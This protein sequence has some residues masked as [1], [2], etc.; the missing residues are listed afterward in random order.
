MKIMS[1]IGIM[2]LVFSSFGW[3]EPDFPEKSIYHLKQEWRDAGRKKVALDSLQGKIQVVTFIYTHC[4]ATCP[5]IVQAFKKIEKQLSQEQQKQISFT[6]F[7]MD[8]E[9][10]TPKVLKSFTRA[11]QIKKTHWRLLTSNQDQVRELAAA[12]DFTFKKSEGGMFL[13]Q[14]TLFLLDERGVVIEQYPN[15]NEAPA[16]VVKELSRLVK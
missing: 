15:L 14:N 16:E 9:R 1:L 3:S 4:K 10:D 2:T 5:L 8:P 7:S 13:H 6:L 11:H 12:L